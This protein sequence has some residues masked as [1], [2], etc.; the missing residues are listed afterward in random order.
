MPSEYTELSCTY[1]SL[2]RI[3]NENPLV[4]ID[5]DEIVCMLCIEHEGLIF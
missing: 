5:D 1:C 3:E 2:D 4:L